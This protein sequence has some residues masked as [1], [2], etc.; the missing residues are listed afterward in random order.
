MPDTNNVCHNCFL[1]S[2]DR[3]QVYVGDHYD[4]LLHRMQPRYEW[5]CQKCRR[6]HL[7]I[8]EYLERMT[9]ATKEA[10]SLDR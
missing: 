3:A 5:W 4:A 6:R 1:P 8:I 2:T 7:A 10:V 9:N